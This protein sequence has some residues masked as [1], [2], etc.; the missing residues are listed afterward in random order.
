MPIEHPL[1]PHGSDTAA[2]RLVSLLEHA[3][4]F[5]RSLAAKDVWVRVIG[6]IDPG[7]TTPA[8]DDLAAA[9]ALTSVLG[10]IIEF[11][12]E[13]QTLGEAS[14]R[15][16]ERVVDELTKSIRLEFVQHAWQE[17]AH[18]I[19]QA[20][21]IHKLELAASH[22]GALSRTRLIAD[23]QI[24]TWV[25]EIESL[26]AAILSDTDLPAHLQHAL[27]DGLE[28]L[29]QAMVGYRMRGQ[30]GLR[31]AIDQFLGRLARIR[32]DLDAEVRENRKPGWLNRFASFLRE[33]EEV[34]TSAAAITD[35][36]KKIGSSVVLGV[37]LCLPSS[38]LAHADNSASEPGLV[39]GH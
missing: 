15:P 22:L 10:L 9:E 21:L 24:A 11:K 27:S 20:H 35:N 8:A 1:L 18:R 3:M 25:G 13:L 23:A 5:P 12:Q 38:S 39:S 32:D 7:A 33:V 4:R 36:V 30:V 17:T 6:G 16:H 29:R 28:Y 19:E 34:S 31:N 14:R 26:H 2:Q 37:V